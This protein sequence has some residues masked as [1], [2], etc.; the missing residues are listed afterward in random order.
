MRDRKFLIKERDR[1]SSSINSLQI[2]LK[3]VEEEIDACE[4]RDTKSLLRKNG[5]RS[6]DEL[7]Q[8]LEFEKKGN[9]QLL[10]AKEEYEI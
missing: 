10:A 1:I 9:E 8:R 4:W 6:L 2:K 7:K 3:Q 5:I